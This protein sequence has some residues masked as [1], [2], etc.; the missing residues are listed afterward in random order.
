MEESFEETISTVLITAKA[1]YPNSFDENAELNMEEIFYHEDGK[2]YN[3]RIAEWYAMD[4]SD[5]RLSYQMILILNTETEWIIPRLLKAKLTKSKT[6]VEIIYGGGPDNDVDCMEYVDG[7][8][9]PE[10]EVE[11][12]PY[13]PNCSCE[14]V[15]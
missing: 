12:P 14:P 13:H 2:Y 3:D 10:D 5:D 15:F 4:L 11:L 9:R 1:L 7:E 6:Y 8:A